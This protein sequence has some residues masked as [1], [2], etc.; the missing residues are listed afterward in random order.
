LKKPQFLLESLKESVPIVAKSFIN[1][2]NARIE[3]LTMAEITV[4][5][6]AVIFARI[7]VSLAMI[8]QIVSSSRRIIHNPTIPMQITVIV[9][10]Q[11][12]THKMQFSR[13]LHVEIFSIFR[14]DPEAYDDKSRS[15]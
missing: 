12:L 3:V 13:T 1:R 4:N 15:T 11:T 5:Q 14:T 9:T 6:V 7:V 10:D 8:G 2:S